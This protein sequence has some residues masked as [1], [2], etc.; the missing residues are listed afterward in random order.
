M[1]A[2]P[3]RASSAG[4]IDTGFFPPR[5]FIATATDLAVVAPAQRHGE[6]IAHFSPERAVLREPQ[7]MGIGRAAATNQTR[8]FGHELDVVSVTKAARLGMDQ[9]ALVDAVGNGNPRGGFSRSS[10]D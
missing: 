10:L 3:Q 8:L 7:M 1:G 9:L 2:Q 4:R 6:L 5:G